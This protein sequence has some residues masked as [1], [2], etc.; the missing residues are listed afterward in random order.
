MDACPYN[1]CPLCCWTEGGSSRLALLTTPTRL[2]FLADVEKL[3]VVTLLSHMWLH[4]LHDQ[5]LSRTFMCFGRISSFQKDAWSPR[6]QLIYIFWVKRHPPCFGGEQLL[7]HSDVRSRLVAGNAAVDKSTSHI[8]CQSKRIVGETVTPV[9]LPV[10]AQVAHEE[11]QPPIPQKTLHLLYFWF[12]NVPPAR[13]VPYKLSGS[14]KY[15][16]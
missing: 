9:V 6:L 5:T 2:V 8:W 1:S 3:S 4:R 16:S 12:F 11:S 13:A 7:V 14:L 10:K 15:F